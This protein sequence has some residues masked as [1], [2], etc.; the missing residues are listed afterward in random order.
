MVETKNDSSGLL[1]RDNLVLRDSITSARVILMSCSA[2]RS[3]CEALFDQFQSGAG[4]ILYRMGE[5]YA[6]KLLGAVPK[7]G[8]ERD[9]IIGGFERLSYLAGWGKL[10]LRLKKDLSA[11]CVVEKSAF[12]LRRADIGPNTCFFFSGVLSSIAKELLKQEYRTREVKCESSGSAFCKF[13]I[14]PV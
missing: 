14:D 12:V 2:Y 4:V 7:L 5:G 1:I 9:V 6:K 10:N 11:E 8:V 3:M 13:E